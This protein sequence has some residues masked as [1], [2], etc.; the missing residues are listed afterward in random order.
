MYEGKFP[1]AAQRKT[2]N[3][4]IKVQK[5]IVLGFRFG[6]YGYSKIRVFRDTEQYES[7]KSEKLE[8]SKILLDES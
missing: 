5:T 3:I 7:G 6:K 4:Q 8:N 2:S 1:R